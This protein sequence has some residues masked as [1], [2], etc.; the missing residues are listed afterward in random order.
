MRGALVAAKSRCEPRRR[1]STPCPRH[2]AGVR[3]STPRL[4]IYYVFDPDI[5][6]DVR[7]GETHAQY[8]ARRREEVEAKYAPVLAY[9]RDELGLNTRPPRCSSPSAQ[10]W[11]EESESEEEAE[12]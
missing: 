5:F 11:V 10:G 8:V 6:D 9:L 3:H 2:T 7:P 12:A 1:H 4:D